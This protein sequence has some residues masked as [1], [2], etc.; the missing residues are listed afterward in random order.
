MT[1]LSSLPHFQLCLTRESQ[2]TC[3]CSVHM[4]QWAAI[5]LD[6]L[7][8]G[9]AKSSSIVHPQKGGPFLM[10]DP[11]KVFMQ[12]LK[13]DCG[14]FRQGIWKSLIPGVW[15]R[16]RSWESKVDRILWPHRFFTHGVPRRGPEQNPSRLYYPIWQP[17]TTCGFWTCA[18][19]LVRVEMQWMS[20]L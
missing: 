9:S 13:V 14:P 18:M 15:S 19:W 16:R 12:T 1:C 11:G 3:P 6:P 20:S 10:M 7:K 17:L 4:S 2:P 8:S 5:P